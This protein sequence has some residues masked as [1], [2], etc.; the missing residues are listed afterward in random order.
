MII[1]CEFR[2][3]LL[4]KK[5]PDEIGGCEHFH[6]SLTTNGLCYTF[7]GQDTTELWKTSEIMTT[8]S[9]ILSSKPV[10]KTFGGPRTWQGKENK[11]NKISW[12][13]Q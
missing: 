10:I 3:N 9:K 7:N 5:L 2:E 11:Q 6:P 13:L 8:F 12:T 1:D 4:K